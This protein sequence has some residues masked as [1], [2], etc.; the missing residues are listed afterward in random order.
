MLGN[1]YTSDDKT[2]ISNALIVGQIFGILLLGFV[3]DWWSRKAGMVFTSSL[4]VVGSLMATLALRVEHLGIENMLWY[5][6]I[7]RGMA[8]V[9][10]GGEFPAGAA[11]SLYLVERR[12]SLM[13]LTFA[14]RPR[15]RGWRITSQ[16]LVVLSS[17]ARRHLSPAGADLSA[18]SCI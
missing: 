7:V 2:R 13:I 14:G 16:S 10:V 6:T 15:V 11:V 8:G 9:G 1:Q 18:Y 3:T 4:V 17:C 5:L 12:L